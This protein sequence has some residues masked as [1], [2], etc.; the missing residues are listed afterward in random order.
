MWAVPGSARWLL[1]GLGPAGADPL[2][3]DAPLAFVFSRRS[4]AR[5]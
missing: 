1:Y 5:R 4:S 3:P 2:G